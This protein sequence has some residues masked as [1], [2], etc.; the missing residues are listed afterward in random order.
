M[1][2]IEHKT[3]TGSTGAVFSD[4]DQY[5][6]RL[7]REWDKS[8]PTICFLMLN[9]STADEHINDP[10]IAR[11]EARAV[12]MKFGRLE[13]VNLFPWRATNPAQLAIVADPLGA[14][15]QA[16]SAIMDAIDRSAT[17]V[18]AWGAHHFAAERAAAVLRF[19]RI[20]GHGF[21]L[22]HLGL[23][24]GGSPKHPLYISAGTRPARMFL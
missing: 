1:K 9:P 24:K 18:C 23:N 2:H 7:W 19:I 14:A 8:L 20:A 22:H 12:V 6:Y 21:K 11:C 16:D 4:C 5:R 17:V 10:T 3:L 15:G 13:V